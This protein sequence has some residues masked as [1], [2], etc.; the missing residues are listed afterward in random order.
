MLS[1]VCCCEQHSGSATFWLPGAA[2]SSATTML[3]PTL[4]LH[5]FL[6]CSMYP[7]KG[8]RAAFVFTAV[9]VFY[10]SPARGAYW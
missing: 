7:C 6:F 2:I 4:I 1:H 5:L 8:M 3:R 10:F 9:P